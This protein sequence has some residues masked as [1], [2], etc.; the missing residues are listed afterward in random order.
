[1]TAIGVAALGLARWVHAELPEMRVAGATGVLLPD[2]TNAAPHHDFSTAEN[3]DTAWLA[4]D[5]ETEQFMLVREVDKRAAVVLRAGDPILDSGTEVWEFGRYQMTPERLLFAVETTRN[6]TMLLAHD[7]ES[8]VRSLFEQDGVNYGDLVNFVAANARGDALVHRTGGQS[9]LTL[10]PAD[11]GEP[12]TIVRNGE[13]IPSVP[14]SVFELAGS[15]FV[16]DDRQV[17]F[18]SFYAGGTVPG[19]GVFFVRGGSTDI[20]QVIVPFPGEPTGTEMCCDL[21]G[22]DVDGIIGIVGQRDYDKFLFVGKPPEL[23]LAFTVPN[24]GVVIPNRPEYPLTNLEMYEVAVGRGGDFVWVSN[25]RVFSWEPEV[26]LRVLA[27]TNDPAP[28]GGTFGNTFTN[29]SADGRGTFQFTS[30]GHTVYRSSRS[31]EDVVVERLAGPADTFEVPFGKVTAQRVDSY[32]DTRAFEAGRTVLTINYSNPE[33]GKESRMIVV[34]GVPLEEPPESS[35]CRVAD[36]RGGFWTIPL[37]ALSLL[38]RTRR[39]ETT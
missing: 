33:T 22:S 24:G 21:V 18:E 6:S 2:G 20:E 30:N 37:L 5:A 10:V 15:A 12:I 39:R 1:M 7:E 31:G 3:G 35:H 4:R 26:G 38:G 28:G 8:G 32:L 11:G 9:E 13:A 14:G 19:S 27:W 25:S 29:L 17:V 16:A 36:E 34:D 23:A